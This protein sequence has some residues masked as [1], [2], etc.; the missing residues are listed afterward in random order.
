MRLLVCCVLVFLDI[1]FCCSTLSAQDQPVSFHRDV[2]PIFRIQ[3]VRCHKPEK[4]K[5]GLDLTSHAAVLKGGESGAVV[6]P[7]IPTEV[8]CLKPSVATSLRCL[9]KANRCCQTKLI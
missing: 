9:K 3:C 4:L 5:G 2:M 8:V 7:E 6:R 1:A